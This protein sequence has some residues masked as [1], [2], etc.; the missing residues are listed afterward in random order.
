MLPI[1][2]KSAL[3]NTNETDVGYGQP[4]VQVCPTLCSNGLGQ[5]LCNCKSEVPT[6]D[7]DWNSVCGTFCETDKY[8]VNGCPPCLEITTQPLQP[9]SEYRALNTVEGWQSWC[10]VQC[11]QGQ[12]GTACNCDR[13]PFL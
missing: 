9:A 10:N 1:G 13:P 12:G 7:V 6:E 8:V 3:M 4:R 11:R 2:L 5:P